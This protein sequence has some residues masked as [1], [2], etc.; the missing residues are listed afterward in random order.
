M[1]AATFPAFVRSDTGASPATCTSAPRRRTWPTSPR[2]RSRRRGRWPS[3]STPGGRRERTAPDLVGAVPQEAD[4]GPGPGSTHHPPVLRPLADRQRLHVDL[5]RGPAPPASSMATVPGINRP[6]LGHAIAEDLAYW[7]R[8]VE[9]PRYHDQAVRALGLDYAA[10]DYATRADVPSCS[11]R[12]T[13][14]SARRRRHRNLMTPPHGRAAAELPRGGGRLHRGRRR[15]L[16]RRGE[17]AP[18]PLEGGRL[19]CPATSAS[20]AAPRT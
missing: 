20:E 6:W 13:P 9:A 18:L 14:T 16:V 2:N 4:P 3:S 10:I 12:P 7:E 1:P 19:P 5:P 8:T 15:R 11:G 17:P